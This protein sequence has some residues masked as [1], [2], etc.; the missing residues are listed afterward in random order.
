MVGPVMADADPHSDW[1]R[2][3]ANASP[4]WDIGRPQP[5]FVRLADAGALTG[6]LLDAGCGTGE[7][8]ILA[9]RNGARAIG[10]D[11]ASVAIEAAQ[12]KA[13]ER[14]V[15]AS[16]HVIDALR[17]DTLGETFDT[18]VDS[19]LFPVLDDDAR[20]RYVAAI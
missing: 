9:A 16:F 12:R 19:R 15:D 10:I 14:G 4:S 18:V 8:P 2:W 3:Y 6:T 17:A 1:N 20:A 13:A 5:A 7:H 11:V